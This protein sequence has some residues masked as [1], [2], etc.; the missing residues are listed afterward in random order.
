[1]VEIMAQTQS[2]Y[3]LLGGEQG[4]RDLVRIFY[5]LVE[6]TPEGEPLVALHNQGSGLSHVRETQ[7]Q[8]LS[9]FFGGPQLYVEQ[10]GHSN[11]RKMH[12]HVAINPVARDSWLVCMDK[13]L[14]QKGVEEGLHQR[15]MAH[16]TRIAAM[17]VN[18]R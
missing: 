5:D 8:F 15:L 18:E 4:V 6:S 3:R 2:P 14:A 11:V 7:F 12:E 17:L 1:M 13:A 10:H 9:G 16:F